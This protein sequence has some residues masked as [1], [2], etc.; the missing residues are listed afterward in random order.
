MPAVGS[1]LCKLLRRWLTFVFGSVAPP[2]FHA[3]LPTPPLSP[4]CSLTTAAVAAHFRKCLTLNGPTNCQFHSSCHHLNK[5]L[6]ISVREQW[7][8]SRIR[9]TAVL[10]SLCHTWHEKVLS[11]SLCACNFCCFWNCFNP[12]QK[13]CCWWSGWIIKLRCENRVLLSFSYL[14]WAG[15]VNIY[16][17]LSNPM[18]VYSI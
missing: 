18:T 16:E 5:R 11:Q 6:K 17:W 8:A 9:N 7:C 1:D 12:L 2:S 3:R 14:F 10:L 15:I 4:G 13:C